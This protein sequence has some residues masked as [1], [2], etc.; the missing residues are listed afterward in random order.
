MRDKNKILINFLIQIPRAGLLKAKTALI[1]INS[2]LNVFLTSI[3]RSLRNFRIPEQLVLPISFHL[4]RFSRSSRITFH[5]SRIHHRETR[6]HSIVSK[7]FHR[8]KFN[9]V[10]S[11]GPPPCFH[12]LY[13]LHRY[14]KF[15][16]NHPIPTKFRFDRFASPSLF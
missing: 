3:I 13:P 7:T 16:L 4:Q 1:N 9:R 5:R 15:L 14:I 2:Q 12:R 6:K 11:H 10:I 8:S